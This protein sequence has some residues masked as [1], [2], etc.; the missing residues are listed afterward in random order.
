MLICLWVIS[1]RGVDQFH[2]NGASLY[3]VIQ[4][5]SN[6]QGK[7]T[8]G[9]NTPGPMGPA[10]A[11]EIPE[12]EDY[13]RITYPNT[14]ALRYSDRYKGMENGIWADESFFELLT[15][16]LSQG[17]K[18]EVLHDP[19][20]IV[21]S[22]SVA[23]RYF[24]GANAM[25]K[26][27]SI[28][29]GYNT[30]EAKVSGVMQDVPTN[31]SLQF[32]FVIPFKK[33]LQ[34]NQWAEN[35]GSSSFKCLVRLN[36]HANLDQ[37]NEK[38][39]PFF[40]Q[41]HQI[42]GSKMLLQEFSQRYL[43][44]DLKAGRIPAGRITYV[45]LFTLI[46]VFIL[47]IACINFMNLATARAGIR[48]KEI[49]VRKV[50]GAQRKNLIWQFLIEA[51]LLAFFSGFIAL[52]LARLLLPT[53]NQ[54]TGKALNLPITDFSFLGGFVALLVLTGLL[55]GSYP[56]FF[57]SA[58]KPI[59]T[60]KGQLVKNK[61]ESFFRKILVVYQLTLSVALIIATMVIYYQIHYIKN[62]SLG[63]N[64]ENIIFLSASPEIFEAQQSFATELKSLPGIAQVSFTNDRPSR[65]YA[66][67]HDPFWEGMKEGE[68]IGFEFL[69]T[70]YDFVETLGINV[71]EGRDFSREFSSD[72]LNYLL[73]QTAVEMMN[74][75]EPLGKQFDFWGRKGEII[76]I[77]EDF[78]YRSL[79]DKIDPFVILLWPENTGYIMVK[80]LP[81]QTTVALSSLKQVYGK[82]AP[83]YPFDYSFLDDDFERDYKSEM[84]IGR[85]ANY[86]TA[87][88]IFISCLGLF[89]LV[90][91]TA[92][93][94]TKEI[95]IR[96]VLGANLNQLISLI[97]KEFMPL[98]LIALVVAIPLAWYLM[99][100]WLRDFYYKVSLEPWIFMAAGM[101]MMV[102]ALLTVGY[103]AVKAGTANPIESLRNE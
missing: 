88:V 58:F 31:S 44:G 2:E 51:T 74:L 90:S 97:S 92:E 91:F 75:E 16:P 20:Q 71:I 37:V 94:K 99:K 61:N 43:Y 49:G 55:S 66:N 82:F 39:E 3:S 38:I 62:K 83:Q 9:D 10:L 96:K 50:I 36:P 52:L 27:V 53:F 1:E 33:F 72:T 98:V 47:L 68:D 25:G 7:V 6:N 87:V 101:A 17:S 77:V 5:G 76:G 46:G 84:L 12:I 26:V 23:D 45:R 64:R 63:M 13:C 18:E 24:K 30:F 40:T 56:S 8:Y 103:Q 73:N 85:L 32:D 70:G 59:K 11:H 86:F 80:T 48:T 81:D 15:F 14:L 95:G 67:T 89:G 42:V 100:Q 69:F 41:H 57:L 54:I 65:V 93:R 29:D 60:L 22:Q 34:I 28:S 102:I 4:E 79:H 35:W 19:N 78:H 21:I